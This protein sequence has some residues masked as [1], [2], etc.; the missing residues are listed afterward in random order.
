MIKKCLYVCSFSIGLSYKFYYATKL[1][2]VKSSNN[3]KTLPDFSFVFLG[4]LQSSLLFPNKH[5]NR[6]ALY[7]ML[8]VI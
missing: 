7:L 6:E 3:L 1:Q 8:H 5:N 2:K 4:T